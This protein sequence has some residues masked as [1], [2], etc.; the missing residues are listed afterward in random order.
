MQGPVAPGGLAIPDSVL[1]IGPLSARFVG[2]L[3]AGFCLLVIAVAAWLRPTRAALVVSMT[4]AAL[5]SFAFLTTM[6]ERYLFPAA[7]LPLALVWWRPARWGVVAV[8]V[9]LL[10]EILATPGVDL[11]SAGLRD[12]LAW[13]RI[14]MSIVVVVG[15][16]GSIGLLGYRH[17]PTDGEWD[18]ATGRR[19]VAPGGDGAV[20][21]RHKWRRRA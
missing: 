5:V 15:A 13:L 1:L 16:I 2:L 19:E 8:S 10:A 14:P 6:H 12:V 7:V 18:D 4:S 9:I 17:L 21:T 3:L 20:V 11:V